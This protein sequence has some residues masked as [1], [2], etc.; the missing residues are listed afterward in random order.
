[1]I[2]G[3]GLGGGGGDGVGGGGGG[4]GGGGG[5]GGGGW[6][7]FL[8]EIYITSPDHLYCIILLLNCSASPQVLSILCVFFCFS[9]IRS[10]IDKPLGFDRD[11]DI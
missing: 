1:M 10:E 8:S 6:K 2:R 4:R 11:F 5:G 7:R 9:L 3:I